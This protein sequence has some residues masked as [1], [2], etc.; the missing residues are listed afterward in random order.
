[1]AVPLRVRCPEERE[2]GQQVIVWSDALGSG[3]PVDHEDHA[4]GEDIVGHD[5][6]VGVAGRPGAVVVQDVGQQ[7]AGRG[8][9][10]AGWIAVPLQRLG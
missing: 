8:G 7:G 1:L 10:F 4:G 9:G 6:A 5:P 3:L 2:L